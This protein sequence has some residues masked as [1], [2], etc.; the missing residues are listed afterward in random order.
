MYVSGSA[1]DALPSSTPKNLPSF[2]IFAVNITG[3]G[4]G[5]DTEIPAQ[6]IQGKLAN[7]AWRNQRAI[8]RGG[9]PSANG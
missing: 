8:R 7:L 4:L 5:P 2:G 9:S 6:L 1:V 3:T